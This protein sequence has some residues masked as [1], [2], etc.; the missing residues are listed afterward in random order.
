MRRAD[1]FRAAEIGDGARH[2]QDAMV[3]A[4]GQVQALQGVAQ[5]LLL[6]IVQAAVTI[7]SDAVKSGIAFALSLNLNV[8]RGAHPRTH[9][10]TGF[11]GRALQFLRREPRHFDLQIDAVEQ[12]SGDA[13]AVTLNLIRRAAAAARRITEIAARTSPRCLFAMGAG[14][15]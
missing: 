15:A 13:A 2:A 1:P 7:Q 8:A 4:R 9:L 14:E 3:G 11:T 12:R 6:V 10:R 5:Q